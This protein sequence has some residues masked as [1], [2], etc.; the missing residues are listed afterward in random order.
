MAFPPICSPFRGDGTKEETRARAAPS[1]VK[2]D[3]IDRT[4][5]GPL[6]MT[7]GKEM[8]CSFVILGAQRTNQ[9][10]RKISHLAVVVR[11]S[12]RPLRARE[13]DGVSSSSSSNDR[14]LDVAASI[15]KAGVRCRDWIAL[16]GKETD[17]RLLSTSPTV[18]ALGGRGVSLLSAKL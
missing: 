17:K 2:I 7:E 3:A 11:P 1:V 16:G 9:R 6:P 10:G 13:F 8:R 15:C 14:V 12:V 4:R 18:I 5:V